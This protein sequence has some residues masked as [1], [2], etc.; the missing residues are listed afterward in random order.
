MK[1]KKVNV[2]SKPRLIYPL[3][4]LLKILDLDKSTYYYTLTKKDKDY[5]TKGYSSYKGTVGQIVDNLI[6]R[7]LK[8]I[9]QTKMTDV[10][11]FNL[12]GEMLFIINIR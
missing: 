2:V 9:N 10:T 11:K 3:I 7:T 4:I 1:K 6:K 5:K 8:Q 12:V